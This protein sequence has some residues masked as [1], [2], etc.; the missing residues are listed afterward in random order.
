LQFFVA[1]VKEKM[2][3]SVDETGQKSGVPEVDDPSAS[4]M[5]N[6]FSGL[7]DVLAAY[8]NLA[9]REHLASLD[10]KQASRVEHDRRRCILRRKQRALC[11]QTG[12]NAS[13]N[14]SGS[15]G[16]ISHRCR[17][18]TTALVPIFRRNYCCGL[19]ACC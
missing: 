19:S 6:R 2:H 11:S 3:V 12:G 7:R 14:Q 10:D 17:D 1:G 18:S 16:T 8:Q 5:V 4:R 13:Q 9:R 15:Q